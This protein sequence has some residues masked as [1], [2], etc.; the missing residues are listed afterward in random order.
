[1][2]KKLFVFVVEHQQGMRP[3]STSQKD[4]LMLRKNSNMIYFQWNSNYH[5][6]M[7]LQ[8]LCIYTDTYIIRIPTNVHIYL[9]TY[10]YGTNLIRTRT[11]PLRNKQEFKEYF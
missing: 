7:Y 5:Y 3:A 11:E 8:Q 2:V 10:L 6:N 4:T 1:M 9:G